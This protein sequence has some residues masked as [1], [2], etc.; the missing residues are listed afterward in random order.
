MF[1]NRDFIAF[2]NDNLKLPATGIEQDWEIELADC[3]RL[4][5]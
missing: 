5:E 2:I 4:S 3:S 1:I